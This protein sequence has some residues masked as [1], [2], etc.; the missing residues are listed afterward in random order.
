MLLYVCFSFCCF[1]C[2]N[3]FF[4][5]VGNEFWCIGGICFYRSFYFC[6]YFNFWFSLCMVKR[7]IGMVLVCLLN[8]WYNN[9]KKKK[10]KKIIEIIMNFIK[11][12]IFDWIIKN[13]VILIM[14]N[15]FLNW[16][17]FFSLWLFFYGISCCF[18]EF[19][20]LI[21][22]WFDFDCYGLVLRLS[23]R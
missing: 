9:K 18:I 13:F 17:R 10:V 14:L 1:W 19:V 21:G 20:L 11:F 15:D 22:F 7:S 4:V 2:W 16:L 23:F 5:F 12:F 3:C 6:V 8:I